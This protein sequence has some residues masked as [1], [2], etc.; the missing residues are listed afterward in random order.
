VQE[1]SNDEFAKVR[2]DGCDPHS[3]PQEQST[4]IGLHLPQGCVSSVVDHLEHLR[5]LTAIW[6]LSN[7][8][9]LVANIICIHPPN[10]SLFPVKVTHSFQLANL[11]RSFTPAIVAIAILRAPIPLRF[12]PAALVVQAA[13]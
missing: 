4:V 6:T 5:L 10:V 8:S 12:A 3:F 13:M 9:P 1:P 7:Y 11:V 2:L